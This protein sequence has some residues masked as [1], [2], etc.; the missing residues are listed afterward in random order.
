MQVSVIIDFKSIRQL[1]T[2]SIPANEIG[3]EFPDGEV[4]TLSL[5]DHVAELMIEWNNFT[6]RHSITRPYQIHFDDVE[7]IIKS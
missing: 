7:I 3:M 2:D 1:L 6:S 5:A 4:L